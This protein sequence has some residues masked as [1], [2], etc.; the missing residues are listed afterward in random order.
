MPHLV[1]RTIGRKL[2]LAVGL[3]TLAVALAGVLWLRHEAATEAPSL[4]PAFRVAILGVLLL[5]GLMGL[6][7]ALAVRFLLEQPLQRLAAGLQRAS[8]GDFL[9]R[10]EAGGDDELGALARTFNTT[11]AAITDLHAARID[12]AAELSAMQREVALKAQLEARLNEL[13]LM[14]RMASALSGTWDL[15]ALCRRV[16]ELAAQRLPDTG[17]AL[18]LADDVTRELVVRAVAQLD[19]AAVGTRLAPGTGLAG[20]AVAERYLV[21]AR[22]EEAA[23]ALPGAPV[24]FASAVAVPLLHPGGCAGVMLYG[25]AGQDAFEEGELRL[26]ASAALQ[27]ATVV[28]SARLQQAMVRLSQTDTLTGV[29]NRRQ[30]FARLELERERAARFGEPFALLLVD[31]DRFREL[32]EAAGHAAG[33]ATLREVATLLQREIREVDLVARYG[34]EEF[35]VVLPR[36]G[37]AEAREAAERVRAAVEGSGFESAPGGRL[38]ISVGGACFPSDSR[39]LAVLVDCADAALFAAK[40]SGRNVA[41][42]HEPGMRVDPARRRDPRATGTA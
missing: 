29:Q 39:D 22:G 33:D 41:L 27:V 10:L 9:H 19:P 25:R 5:A 1:R 7:H 8:R 17:F 21:Q 18:L 12:D 11:L 31:V 13:E 40:R 28:E 16:A 6:I 20:R 4:E 26:I 35:A 34:G 38:T 14:H 42:L 32:N 36:T 37:P 30:L 3:P 23:A 2:F 24:R 15:E